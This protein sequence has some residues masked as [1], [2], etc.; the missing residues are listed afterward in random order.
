M[1]GVTPATIKMPRL[2]E[3]TTLLWFTTPGSI[4][5]LRTRCIQNYR[6]KISFTILQDR[7]V[8]KSPLFQRMTSASRLSFQF[9]C[10]YILPEHHPFQFVV[11]KSVIHTW[12]RFADS[13]SKV[14]P[15]VIFDNYLFNIVVLIYM[16]TK[17]NSCNMLFIF[18]KR[19]FTLLLSIIKLRIYACINIINGLTCSPFPHPTDFYCSGACIK[20]WRWQYV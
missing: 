4:S 8:L 14:I 13:P 1:Y 10:E 5:T 16:L 9:V 7:R 20:N 6:Y 2:S 12:A 11:I 15:V 3:P 19:N 17:Q 18:S